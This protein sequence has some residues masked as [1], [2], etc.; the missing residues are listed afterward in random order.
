[1][2]SGTAYDA[3]L[4]GTAPKGQET[5]TY[6]VLSGDTTGAIA[7]GP[8]SAINTL[9]GI[10]LNVAATVVSFSRSTSRSCGK[11]PW[12]DAPIFQH[13]LSPVGLE[14]HEVSSEE[15]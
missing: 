6:T 14:R 2:L 15:R 12:H 10:N 8:Q 3:S 5:A 11:R 1:M 4:I 9:V 13:R 7:S